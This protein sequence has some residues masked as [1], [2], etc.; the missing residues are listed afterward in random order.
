M[1]F[2]GLIQSSDEVPSHPA[3]LEL[4]LRKESCP[5]QW[6]VAKLGF[7]HPQEGLWPG[8]LTTLASRREHFC[9]EWKNVQFRTSVFVFLL[10]LPLIPETVFLSARFGGEQKE[11]LISCWWTKHRPKVLACFGSRCASVEFAFES[12]FSFLPISKDQSQLKL[13][14]HG[15]VRC[16]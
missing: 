11:R 8:A 2:W 5:A 6:P 1:A 10:K 16:Q 3:A 9:G 13:Q 12:G 7:T 14:E 4:G 15:S